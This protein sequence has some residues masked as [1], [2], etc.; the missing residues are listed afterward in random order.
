VRLTKTPANVRRKLRLMAIVPNSG[1]NTK[2]RNA[3]ARLA[4]SKEIG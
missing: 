3:T 2:P 4:A 1:G